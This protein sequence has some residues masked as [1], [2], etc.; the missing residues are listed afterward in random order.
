MKKWICVLAILSGL[1]A[2]SSSETPVDP[3]ALPNGIMQAVEGTGAVEGGSFIPEI[4][5]SSMP[6]NMK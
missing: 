1:T 3:D 4:E 5:K 6:E 2:C